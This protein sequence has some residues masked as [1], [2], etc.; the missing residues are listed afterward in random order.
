MLF[1]S[2]RR[3]LQIPITRKG[4][5]AVWLADQEAQLPIL[6]GRLLQ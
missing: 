3:L 2:R 6:R 5:D 4:G 1:D